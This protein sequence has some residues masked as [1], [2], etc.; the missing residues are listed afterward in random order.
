MSIRLSLLLAVS[1]LAAGTQLSHSHEETRY[2]TA[3]HFPDVPGY[4]TL[5]CDFHI[6]TVFSDGLVW[7][8]VRSEEAWR[9]G[10]DA[11][12]ITDHI[13]Y[14]P[15]HADMPT[16]HNRAY[17]LAN[18]AGKD[19]S[20]MVV[21]GSEITRSMPPGHLN[22]IFLTNSDPLDTT[23]WHDAVAAAHDQKAFIFWN[24][25]GWE[26]QQSNGVTVWYPEHT[27]LLEEGMLHGIE[28]V[29]T[30]EYYPEAHRWAIEKKLAMLSNSD[31][32]Q[33]LNLDYHVHE[34][35]H[36][37]LTIVFAKARSQES[38]REALFERRTAVYSGNRLIGD[39]QFLRPI[40][41]GSIKLDRSAVTLKGKKSVLVQISNSSDVAYEMELIRPVGGCDAPRRLTLVANST[42]IL[43]LKANP[44]STSSETSLRY[45]VSN[46]LVG[47]DQPMEVGL[48]LA[49]TVAA[50]DQ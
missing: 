38:L 10:L 40:F 6:H 24:H 1:A 50:K 34:G 35:D 25:P 43:E 41:E 5:K 3:V 47:P 42:V 4:I 26:R 27:Q 46:L 16:N 32:H 18:T 37:P 36:R 49:I 31:I 12:A 33:P 22:A 39:E 13:E 2:R 45:K 14:H 23:N 28:V 30:R 7:P 8:T 21:H 15:H 11:I 19:L 9:E 20:L 29:N 17:Q 48:P 44:K